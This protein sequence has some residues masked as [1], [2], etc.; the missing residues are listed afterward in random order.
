MPAFTSAPQPPADSAIAKLLKAAKLEPTKRSIVLSDGTPLEFWMKPLVAAERRIARER[1][2]SEADATRYAI[3]L[4]I[5]K[6]RDGAG[7]PLFTEGMAGD[8]ES[9]VLEEDLI[10]IQAELYKTAAEIRL[11]MKS[12]SASVQEA[13]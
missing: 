5:L 9:I 8:L 6:A 12:A 4:M 13:S 2:G 1:A 10:K 3:H 11:D 7:A